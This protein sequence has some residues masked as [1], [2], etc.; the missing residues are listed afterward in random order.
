MK[1]WE[2]M[3]QS[4]KDMSAKEEAEGGEDGTMSQT[5]IERVIVFPDCSCKNVLVQLDKYTGAIG[6]YMEHGKPCMKLHKVREAPEVM[7]KKLFSQMK[8]SDFLQSKVYLGA[9][10]PVDRTRVAELRDHLRRKGV[11][12]VEAIFNESPR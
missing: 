6:A 7:R 9:L 3:K 5:T 8:A 11:D 10:R 1:V 2:R 12:R 4:Q